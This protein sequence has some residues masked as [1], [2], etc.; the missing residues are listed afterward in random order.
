M[1]K[2]LFPIIF[3][4]ISCANENKNCLSEKNIP[5]IRE[6]VGKIQK[7]YKNKNYLGIKKH[8]DSLQIVDY[9]FE[10]V[11]SLLEE[12]IHADSS[13]YLFEEIED[14]SN[15]GKIRVTFISVEIISDDDGEHRME[16][17]VS[18]LFEK[19]NG[20]LRITNLGFAG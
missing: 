10:R 14:G 12:S 8:I 2:I 4:V 11:K 7:L 9:K 20:K 3:L 13:E 5:E 6:E 15:C 16:T 18:I 19:N 1:K 17:S